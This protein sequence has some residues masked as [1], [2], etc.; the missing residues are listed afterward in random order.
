V[1]AKLATETNAQY[2]ITGTAHLETPAG[3]PVDVDFDGSGSFPV[4]PIPAH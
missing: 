2:R 3:L 1:L 4:P